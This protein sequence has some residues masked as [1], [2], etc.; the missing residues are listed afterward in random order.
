MN[1]KTLILGSPQASIDT[2]QAYGHHNVRKIGN[3]KVSIS[4][5]VSGRPEMAVDTSYLLQAS[6][7]YDISPNINDYVLAR[8]PALTSEIPN[9]N[10]QAFFAKNLLEFDP[11]MSRLRYK[12]FVARPCCAEH[13]NKVLNRSKGIILDASIVS[14]PKYRVSKVMLLMAFCRQKDPALCNNILAGNGTYSIG[15]LAG[16]FQ[17]SI[18]G[19]VLGPGCN[20]T[21]T[22]YHS[23]YTDL[24]SL[25]GVYGGK[26]HYHIA[27]D[28]VFIECSW[29]SDPADET[30]WGGL[31]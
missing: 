26:L 3:N 28:P 30:A 16:T 2:R 9:R 29:V 6:Q 17:C 31:V 27:L 22:C 24:S 12:T 15:A 7:Y 5:S 4:S 13:D 1:K 25:G 19:G 18:C 10:M 11:E 8:V 20:R 21:C 23:N 14:V